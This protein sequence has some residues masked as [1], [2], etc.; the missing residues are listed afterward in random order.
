VTSR[1]VEYLEVPRTGG[2]TA[3]VDL[4]LRELRDRE[5]VILAFP[6]G[7][8]LRRWAESIPGVEAQPVAFA[9]AG[10]T[11]SWIHPGRVRRL[12]TLFRQARIV[13]FHLHTP[14][15]CT[16]AIALA[17]RAGVSR[18]ITTEHYIAQLSFLRRR[19]RGALIA[20]LREARIAGALAAKRWSLHLVDD[21]VTLSGD[22]R[23][24]YESFAGPRQRPR[25][26]VIHNGIDLTRFDA[27]AGERSEQ[28]LRTDKRHPLVVTV[29]GL[30]NQKGHIH[31]IRAIPRVLQKVASARFLFA[32]EGHLRDHLE[33]T[34]GALGLRDV[35]T[36]AGDRS[37]IPALLA[38]SDLFVLPSL[39]E[40]MPMS[41]LEAMAAG[42]AVVATDVGGTR[43]LV[44]PGETGLLVPP[45]DS[46]SLAHAIV[47]LLLSEERRE[48]LGR[49]GRRRAE[50]H[51]SAA[52]MGARY[53][54]LLD[55][56]RPYGEQ[57]ESA[58]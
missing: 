53:R 48:A 24:D 27:H 57:A 37:D 26:H 34:A 47:E 28:P 19:R 20:A 49:A 1:L 17:R 45:G 33:A 40:G 2:V 9:P 10:M 41:V 25:V 12:Y 6:G 15:S 52:E 44:V 55:K 22:N 32:G 43:D 56:V 13:H 11:L 7:D 31:L 18:I 50:E 5:P 38:S 30:N 36:F 3:M 14:F 21:V 8:P 35:V 42:K 23:S 16:A 46:D 54:R 58:R 51:F 29:A 39:F 4:L